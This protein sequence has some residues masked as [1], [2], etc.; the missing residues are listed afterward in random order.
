MKAIIIE[1][2]P[3][4]V[5]NLKFYLKEYPLDIMGAA[6][7]IKDA[8][9]LIVNA[10][11]EVIFLDIN[12]SGENGFELIEQVNVNFKIIF[13]TAY[14]EYAIRAFE[15]NAFD[16]ILKPLNKERIAKTVERL[17]HNTHAAPQKLQ[18]T[19]DDTVFLASGKRAFFLRLKD[20]RYIQA[21]SCYSKIILSDKI[22]K[23]SAKTLKKW[24]EILPQNEFVRIHR[25]FII[26]INHINK[27]FKK[28][29]ST[30]E[31]LI[32]NINEPIE[33]S[34]RCASVLKN[35]LNL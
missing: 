2:E 4:A 30:Y 22:S 24:G 16:Y 11:P 5:D 1:D 27:I 34:R 21:D 14:N 31:V 6:H 17:L 7:N 35:K 33:I 13:V 20:I 19:L 15:I 3:L 9:K 18:Y 10:K 25:S 12:L 32:N 29:N 8:V 23:Y 26:N 28:D